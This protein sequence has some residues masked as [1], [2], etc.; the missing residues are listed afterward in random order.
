MFI[1]TEDKVVPNDWGIQFAKAQQ[2][3]VHFIHDDHRLTKT[4]PRLPTL[5]KPYIKS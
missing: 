4:L 1:G 2:A 3:M 5:I